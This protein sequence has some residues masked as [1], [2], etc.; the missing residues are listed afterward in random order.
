MTSMSAF[1]FKHRIG[2]LALGVLMVLRM[3]CSAD[4]QTDEDFTPGTLSR[5]CSRNTLIPCITSDC[6]WER[7]ISGVIRNFA[8]VALSSWVAGAKRSPFGNLFFFFVITM[9][10]FCLMHLQFRCNYYERLTVRSQAFSRPEDL[11][12]RSR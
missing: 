9:L 4:A 10:M 8:V 7:S 1:N 2:L 11:E 6:S 5:L 3:I 12:T